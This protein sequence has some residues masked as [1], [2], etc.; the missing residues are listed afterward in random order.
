M[1]TN[2]R[3]MLNAAT[4]GALI[5]TANK[6]LAR[7]L[8]SKFD[9]GM[10]AAGK[11]VWDTPQILSFDAWVVRCLNDLGESWRLL[12]GFLAQRL[13]ETLIEKETADVELL[14]TGATARR[15][16]QA[17]QLLTSYNCQE[18]GLPLTKD[19]EVFLD[20]QLSFKKACDKEQ[21][22]DRATATKLVLGLIEAKS[23]TL[24]SEIF[25]CGF[26]QWPPE[27]EDLRLAHENQGGSIKAIT[28]GLDE[29]A[30]ILCVPCPDTTLEVD[31]AA[32]WARQLLDQ[33]ETSIGVVVLDLKERR[34]LIE[35]TFRHQIE[36]DTA[37]QRPNSEPI[38]SLS[39]GRPLL[40]QGAIYAAVEILSTGARLTIDQVSFLLRTPY[41]GDHLREADPRAILDRRL[42]S[43]RQKEIPL[44]QLI[45]IA[46]ED[47]KLPAISKTLTLL[48]EADES[49]RLP[50]EWAMAFDHLLQSVGWPG[51]T[52]L[53]SYE[54]QV[55]KAW[56]EKLLPSLASLDQISEPM[57]RKQALALLRRLAGESEFQIESE[58]GPVQILG[59]LESAGLTFDHLWVMGM[60]ESNLPSSAQPNPF[61]PTS[62]QVT[63]KMPHASAER[64]LEFAMAVVNR[65]KRAA[66][67][68][69]FSYAQQAGDCELRPS[70]LMPSFELSPFTLPVYHDAYHRLMDSAPE[71]L[72]INDTLGPKLSSKHSKGGTS[73]LKDQ[74]LCPFRAFAHSRLGSRAIE[75]AEPGLDPRTRG[76]LL[77]K[78]LEYFWDEIKE[79]KNLFA[80]TD[81]S[82]H[83]LIRKHA[84]QAIEDYFAKRM[85][86]AAK[87]LEL[88]ISRIESLVGEW[89][90]EVEE[91]RP[92]FVVEAIEQEQIIQI[93]ALAIRTFI[94]RIDRLE[95][96]QLVI[97]DYKTGA[98]KLDALLDDRLLEPQLPIYTTAGDIDAV[99]FAQVRRGSCKMLGIARDDGLLPKVASIENSKKAQ[100][101][102][103][104]G[105]LELMDYWQ[106]Q[107][108]HLADAFVAGNALVDPV[109]FE[110]ACKY[111]DLKSLCRIA[112][113]KTIANQGEEQ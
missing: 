51:D 5:L 102:G 95:D 81:S 111:C 59:L 71:M 83:E 21:W 41:L 62:L 8:R 97:L 4:R 49:R 52:T 50:G 69:I 78:T 104:T 45:K 56:R 24:P 39:L 77:H 112:E 70:P 89:L 76:D 55:L 99:A 106:A 18:H 40:D 33:G 23:L 65:L 108:T 11:T 79:Q 36:P 16:Q 93:G 29:E 34:N 19:Q 26:D 90:S 64:E 12:D 25:V 48:S 32:S 92:A 31:M 53:T 9:N 7:Y 61:L 96:N 35:R 6:R 91:N 85:A 109:D 3:Q 13:W 38:L 58:P 113:A 105:W 80:L 110:S 66:P 100:A 103:I 37:L 15:A 72:E 1:N 44:K 22:L 27:L 88:E 74:A 10:Q 82:R 101:L 86:P 43:F 98:M 75:P 84:K 60:N 17:H 54:Y 94:D 107:L 63:R 67:T 42:R 2:L 28:L 73:I 68:V 87:V 14:Q 57:S 30:K 46:K 47:Q 20:W